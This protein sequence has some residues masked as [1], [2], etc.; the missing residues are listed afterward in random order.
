MAHVRRLFLVCLVWLTAVTTL[1]AGLPQV[2]CRCPDGR[3][4]AF[5]LSSLVGK[6]CCHDDHCCAMAPDD[7]PATTCCCSQKIEADATALRLE[8]PACSKTLVEPS[9]Y[10]LAEAPTTLAKDISAP[11]W[12]LPATASMVLDLDPVSRGPLF[13]HFLAVP[14][15]RVI[16]FQHFLI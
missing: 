14:S 16:V 11:G 12:F 7:E 2:Q 5:C 13:P 4:K 1:V 15:D 8:A 6:N 9:I 10:A 3:I